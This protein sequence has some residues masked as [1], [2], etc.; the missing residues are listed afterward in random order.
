MAGVPVEFDREIVQ[1]WRDTFE[2]D[3]V[4]HIKGAIP[5][6]EVAALRVALE[7][8]FNR[9]DTEGVG[10]R[11]DMT[12]AA[13]EVRKQGGG[14]R[15]LEEAGEHSGRYLTEIEA[16]RWHE[17]LRNFEHNSILP[18]IIAQLLHT[19]SLRFFMDH[20]FLKEPGSLLRTA[21]HQD[22]PYFPFEGQQAAVCWVPVDAVTRDSGAMAYIRGSHR[23]CEYMPSTLI[24]NDP[25]HKSD[26]PKLP[27][28]L[29][30]ESDFD[31]VYFDA[32]PGDVI[33]HHPN[34]V[35]GSA[36]NVSANNRRL[37]ASLRYTGDDIRWLN[38]PTNVPP[39][40]LND[41]WSVE[42]QVSIPS[43]VAQIAGYV[44]RRV[45]RSVGFRPAGSQPNDYEESIMWCYGEMRNG[46]TLDARDCARCAF[47]VVWPKAENNYDGLGEH[48]RAN[49][50]H[51]SRL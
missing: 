22:L 28:I 36:G 34:T 25:T 39:I 16:G 33:V 30:H 45:I 38:K 51:R 5:A 6:D 14:D 43:I 15:L 48:G 41:M 27:D 1:R 7:D 35:H 46:E 44:G 21:F 40:R 50:Q 19:K 2:R 13:D 18:Y 24:T 23:W 12:A 8:I 3:G 31:V 10:A 11:T 17:G 29:G 9:Q 4:V 20:I 47:P 49:V 26:A 37:A 32:E 42:R